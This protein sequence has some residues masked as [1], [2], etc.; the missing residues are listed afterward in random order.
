MWKRWKAS[1]FGRSVHLAVKVRCP[2]LHSLV[3][4][5]CDA[6]FP[7]DIHHGYC[8]LTDHPVLDTETN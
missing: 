2:G 5:I 4:R 3:H 7:Q 6:C 1:S 8:S